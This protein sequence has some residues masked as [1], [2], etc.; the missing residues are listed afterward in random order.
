MKDIKY[1]YCLNEN[2]ELVHISSVTKDNKHS[3][4]YK[5]LECGQKLVARIGD[6]KVKHFAHTANTVCDGESYLHKLAKRRIREQFLS[7]DSFPLTFVRDVPCQES[8]KCPFWV[9]YYCI[10]ERVSIRTNLRIWDGKVVYDT[11]REEVKVDDFRPDLLLSCKNTAK[12]YVFIEI[13]ASHKSEEQKV[14]SKYRIIETIKITSEAVIDDIIKRGFVE[15]ENCNTFNFKP[16]LP[17]IN[18]GGMPI[19]RF[20]L[21]NNGASRVDEYNL[22]CDKSKQRVERNSVMELNISQAAYLRG[23]E[24]FEN[25]LNSYQSGLVYLRKK[26]LQFRNC[27]LCKFYKS[28]YSGDGKICILYKKL[29]ASTKRPQQSQ[30]TNCPR[31]EE[32]PELMNYPLSELEKYI[33]EVP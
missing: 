11:C 13:F 15:G 10:S 8:R 21:F 22:T 27:I 23:D 25:R 33:T 30:A 19:C 4:T 5:C 2:N 14:G 29:G 9:D 20:A 7:A 26:G 24:V 3:H 17:L 6:Y 18:K 12:P 16:T 1:S 31:Y 28:N 32:N